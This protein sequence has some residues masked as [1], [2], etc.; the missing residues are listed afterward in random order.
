V[1]PVRMPVPLARVAWNGGPVSLDLVAQPWWVAA[2]MPAA[3]WLPTNPLA[4]P[5]FTLTYVDDRPALDWENVAYGG[6]LK[7]SLDLL[8]GLD[9]GATFYRGRLS[10]P[11]A[12]ATIT[13]MSSAVIALEY[14]TATVAGADLVLA[15]GAGIL[16]KT[17]WA[18]TTLRDTD[19]LEPEAAAAS[20]E[21][22]S[23]VE[24]SIGSFRVI[25]EYVYDWTK[26]DTA[27]GDITRHT[28][29]LIVSGDIGSR[30]SLR[31]AGIYDF[32]DDGSGM[33]TPQVTYTLADGL[34]LSCVSFFFMGDSTT[35][36]G[37]WKDNA[38]GRIALKY[39]F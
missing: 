29:V 31:V 1:D 14:D 21:G 17:E 13:G 15:P 36:Y 38:V 19:F 6:H 26:G 35:R 16:L 3:R 22:V 8:Q 27:A 9:L 34:S 32:T 12:V 4:A 37:A 33:V 23:G 10:T 18:Y 30:L 7:A 2:A 28:A 20:L 11:R 39:S 25:G 5:G 24:Y